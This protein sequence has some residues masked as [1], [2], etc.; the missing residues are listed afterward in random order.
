M[1]QF[2]TE[3]T[4]DQIPSCV[5]CKTKAE[6]LPMYIRTR[7]SRQ[8]HMGLVLACNEDYLLHR[9]HYGDD[10]TF[11]MWSYTWRGV[12][13]S[14]RLEESS[15]FCNTACLN[16]WWAERQRA[17]LDKLYGE[18][19]AEPSFC[20]SPV[21][22][23]TIASPHEATKHPRVKDFCNRLQSVGYYAGVWS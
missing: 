5:Q 3:I 10:V 23:S 20:S 11:K 16:G 15:Y 21:I 2:K 17:F 6:P 8:S 19:L 18:P 7:S 9:T 4:E 13:L 1:L 14:S 22:V 12:F